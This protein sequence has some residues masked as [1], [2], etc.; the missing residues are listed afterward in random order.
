MTLYTLQTVKVIML[1]D[2]YTFAI[3]KA[4]NVE[5]HYI[6]CKLQKS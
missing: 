4:Y 6:L 5:Q 1:F 2:I 3:C